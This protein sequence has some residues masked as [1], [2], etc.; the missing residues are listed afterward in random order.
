MTPQ[1]FFAATSREVLK[2]VRQA[3]GDDAL[4][5]SN[6]SASGGVQVTA[7]AARALEPSPEP[8]KAQVPAQAAAHDEPTV[9]LLMREVTALKTTLQRELSAIA[10]SDMRHRAPARSRIVQSLLKAGFSPS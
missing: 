10:W 3:L 9:A 6:S 8:R 7:L 2:K 4:I 1:T 5:V